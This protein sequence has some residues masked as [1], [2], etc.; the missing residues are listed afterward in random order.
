MDSGQNPT[1]RRPDRREN[2]AEDLHLD[3]VV[4]SQPEI[5]PTPPDGG[6]GWLIVFSAVI[7]HVTVPGVLTLYGLI[8]L[9]AMGDLNHQQDELM[10]IWDMDIALVP[11]I[12]IVMRLL[13]ESWCRAVVKTFNMPRFI[14]LSGLCLT[15]AGILLSSYST[16]ANSNDHIIN[17]F[18]GMFAGAGCALTGQQI[19]VIIT[20]YFR[21]RLTTAQRL[22]RMAPS[23]G[24]CLVP[25]LVGRL[26]TSYSDGYVVVMI[27]GAI[28][29]QNCLFLA[30]FTRPV[31]IERVIRNTYNM[32]RDAVED[33]DEVIFSN[34]RQ[35]DPERNVQPQSSTQQDDDATDVVVF[36]S[37]KNAKEIVDPTIQYRE[38]T[39][40]V[41]NQQNQ[42]RFSSDFS[43]ILAASTNRFSSDF[44]SLDVA[45]YGRVSGYRELESIDRSQPQPLYRE[46][47]EAPGQSVVFGAEISPGTARRTASLRKN[48]ITVVN[49]LLDLNFYLYALL[50]LTTTTSIFVLGVWFAP[51]VKAKN[52]SMNIWGVATLMAA[53]HGAALCFIMLCV[54][55]PKAIHEKAR[56]CTLFCIAGA[57]G[58]YGITLSTNK[59]LLLIWCM[60]ASFSTAATSI[61]QQPL[62]N[63]TLNEFDTTATTTAANV[64]VAIFLLAWSLS[65]NY[66]YVA[67]FETAAV[68][69]VVTAGVFLAS[70]FRRR[71]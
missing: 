30:S 64:I 12:M 71:R 21:D 18:S 37:K 11:V 32:L 13:L 4:A 10:R 51:V 28:L 15:V 33:D 44:G 52:A 68:L 14:A 63:S 17:I 3:R 66:A 41:S 22:V 70:S 54:V 8:I 62:Y 36:K 9:N 46:T 58:F 39:V 55:L 53:A 48:F 40:T 5:G 23:V 7:Y 57:M 6:Y 42:P 2:V 16:D 26:C 56:L 61:I 67:C 65:R 34:Q 20:H 25:I 59:S 38:K 19:E 24:N 35:E 27:Y 60:F 45:S 47:T 49:M 43:E 29:M 31:Y 69:Q 1:P 50:H